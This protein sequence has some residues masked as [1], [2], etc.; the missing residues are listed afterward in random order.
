MGNPGGQNVS[1]RSRGAPSSPC[2][3]EPPPRTRRTR[4]C[5]CHD[6]HGACVMTPTARV[7]Q[8]PRCVSHY[9]HD[10][11][12]DPHGA[13]LTT[14]TEPWSSQSNLIAKLSKHKTQDYTLFLPTVGHGPTPEGESPWEAASDPDL[15]PEGGWC[16]G[17]WD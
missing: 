8:P 5:V 7:P 1:Q 9:P 4:G 17:S 2:L 15:S 16:R 12:H 13:C 3:R 6:P 14:P 10:A 11:C